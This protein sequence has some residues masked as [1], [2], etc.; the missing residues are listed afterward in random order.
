V[1]RRVRQA[2][3]AFEDVTA[4]ATSASRGRLD[5]FESVDLRDVA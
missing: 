2:D 5:L 4:A 1:I 3:A